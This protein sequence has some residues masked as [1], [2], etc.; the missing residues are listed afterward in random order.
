MVHLNAA[1]HGGGVTPRE[2]QVRVLLAR[3]Q[4]LDNHRPARPDLLAQDA[5][6]EGI[7]PGDLHAALHAL[8]AAGL[9]MRV[10]GGWVARPPAFP[11]DVTE[12]RAARM[13]LG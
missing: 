9:A 7:P 3:R 11:R 6:A 10:P 1:A 12:A 8:A 13:R 2:Q 5:A 4:A